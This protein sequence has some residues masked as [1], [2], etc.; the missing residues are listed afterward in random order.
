MHGLL[1]LGHSNKSSL[2]FY[3]SFAY[4]MVNIACIVSSTFSQKDILLSHN[5]I[6][7]LTFLSLAV[8]KKKKLN[9]CPIEAPL[10]SVVL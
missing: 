1:I 10:K 9:G 2:I 3:I 7:R 5:Y 8:L 6:N 4:I